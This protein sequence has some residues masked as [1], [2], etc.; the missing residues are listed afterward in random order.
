M[1]N[2][3]YFITW[4][5]Q[6]G[7]KKIDIVDSKGSFYIREDGQKVHDLCSTSYHTAFGHSF[8]PIKKAITKQLNTL[9][10]ASPK[11]TF[12][13]KDSVSSKLIDLIGLKGKVFYTVSGAEAIENALKAARQISGKKIILSRNISYHGAT[14]G[15]LSI[16]GDWRNKDHATVSNWTKRIPEPEIDPNGEKLEELILKTGPEKIAGICLETITG[17]NGVIIPPKSWWRA[18]TRLKKK[19]NLLLILDEVV[20]GFGR[21][22]KDFGFQHFN[23]KP[24]F[25]CMAKVITGGY[26]PFGAVWFNSKTAKYYDK[27]TLCAGLTNYAHPLGLAAMDVVIDYLKTN[28]HK[29]KFHNLEIVMKEYKS[30]FNSLSSVKETRQIGLI[31][32]IELHSPIALNK[33]FENNLFLASVGNN[34]I[35]APAYI[36]NPN[37]LKK[38]FKLI[39]KI[40]KGHI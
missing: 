39:A 21:T 35:L 31:M 22:G 13:L 3:P 20:C 23:L 1:D 28:E 18:I 37:D 8:S 16:T 5:K 12:D 38:S 40:I 2:H 17:G 26:I 27:N 14:L 7:A 34:L 33:F 9:P 6:V 15:A 19:Y 4:T 36:T 29:E 30:V 10:M 24:D 25:I 32:A 11:C